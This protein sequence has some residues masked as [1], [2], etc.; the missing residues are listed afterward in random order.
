M[1]VEKPG[2]HRGLAKVRSRKDNAQGAGTPY[3]S[4]FP[5]HDTGVTLLKYNPIT[6]HQGTNQAF[7]EAS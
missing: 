7:T 1:S 5:D 2:L 6:F 4:S 3:T